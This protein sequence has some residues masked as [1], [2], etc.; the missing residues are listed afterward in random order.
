MSLPYE[1]HIT[2]SDGDVDEFKTACR[3]AGVKP[4]L[5]DLYTKGGTFPDLQTSSIKKTEDWREIIKEIS[6]ITEILKTHG[7]EVIRQK[8]EA[9]PFHFMAPTFENGKS[10]PLGSYFETHISAEVSTVDQYYQLVSIAGKYKAHVSRNIFKQTRLGDMVYMVTLREHSEPYETF[11]WLKEK[12]LS[13]LEA[14]DFVVSR[15]V[16]EFVV[17]DTNLT[18]DKEWI[19]N[20]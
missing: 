5:L 1:I 10:M 9:P 7:F 4:I 13:E 18:H 8:V 14:N 2:V 19:Q 16:A 17:N 6:R 3:E 20:S 15:A 12:L 11:E